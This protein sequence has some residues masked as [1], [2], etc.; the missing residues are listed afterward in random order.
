M[1]SILP[2][3]NVIITAAQ[4]SREQEAR[5]RNEDIFYYYIKSFDREELRLAVQNAL[6]PKGKAV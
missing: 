4:N 2:H 3:A 5:I 6:I 1:K